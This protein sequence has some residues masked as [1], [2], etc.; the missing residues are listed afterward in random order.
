MQKF[1]GSAQKDPTA[2]E[3]ADE[4]NT[5]DLG[6]I[7]LDN[8]DVENELFDKIDDEKLP[9]LKNTY[10]KKNR[11]NNSKS[12]AAGSRTKV[13]TGNVTNDEDAFLAAM[14]HRPVKSTPPVEPKLAQPQ[15]SA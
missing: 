15:P 7:D 11:P 2:V 14:E 12:I 10:K 6:I 3:V 5:E 4:M 9:V 1:G 8:D 13:L